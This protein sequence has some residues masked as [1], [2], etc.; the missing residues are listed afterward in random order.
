[1][2]ENETAISQFGF[3]KKMKIRSKLI[4]M[5]SLIIIVSLS[6]MIFIATFFFKSDKE[7][8]HKLA[9]VISLKVESD[10]IS[11][12]EKV[13]LMGT[14]LR[15]RFASKAQKDLFTGLFFKNDKNFI[16]LGIAGKDLTG[17][18]ILFTDRVA[19]AA[20]LADSR[21]T[22]PEIEQAANV[23]AESFF[24]SFGNDT[25]VNNVSAALKQPML[26]ISIPFEKNPDG[27]VQTILV[28]Y[29]KLEKFLQIFQSTES[30]ITLT[31][32]INNQGDIIGHPDS[33]IVMSQA[34]YLNVPIVQ[35]M[36]KHPLD[37]GQI[38]YENTDGIYHIGSFKKSGFAGVGVV[39]TVE[40]DRAFEAVYQIQRRNILLTVIILNIAILIVYFFAK[41]LT[42][43]ILT[44][45]G[46]TKEIEQGNFI[47]D[48]K[49]ATGDEIGQLTE[50]FVAMGQGLDERERMKDAFGK[51]VNKEIAEQVL[52]G[53]IKLGGERKHAAVFFSDIRAFTAISEQLEPEEVVEFLN[54][55]MTAMVNC[56]NESKGVVDKFIG[57]AIMAIWGA[58]VSHGNDAEN[59][60]TGA[61]M[62]R[63]ALRKFNVGRGGPKKPVIKIGSGINYGPVLA[64]QIGSNERMEYT[65]IGDTVNLAS[66]VEALNKPFGTD[67]LITEEVRSR[68]GKVFRVEAMQKIKVKGKTDPQQIYAVLGRFDDPTAPKTIEEMRAMLGIDMKGK[69]TE[70]DAE[71]GEVKY[72]IIE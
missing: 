51:F 56:V 17:K 49:P 36:M 62:M 66:R 34:N 58:P 1:M 59:A 57:D 68:V 60:V 9:E 54:E 8:N 25:V 46:A 10:F 16:Y 15:Q 67:I 20:F 12:V 3:L 40:E 44:L 24:R 7:T 30:G 71:A 23:Y 50:S 18:K 52:K 43:P 28:A 26:G 13:N 32:M 45:L 37:N 65:V 19:S 6:A 69:P 47:V 41:T 61:L 53:T 31:Y 35:M 72:E 70:G 29:I 63:E 38:R 27:S 4:S 22:V 64:G 2:N 42:G 11:L 55:Y 39:A 33:N 5:I 21:S 14:T 48:I